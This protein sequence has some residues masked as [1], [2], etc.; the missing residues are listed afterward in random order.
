MWKKDYLDRKKYAEF[1]Y[2]LISNSDKYKRAEGE[3]AYV[4]ALDSPWGTGKSYF[5][6]I[7]EKWLTEEK[8]IQVIH[9]SAWEND[10]WDN[11]FL[12]LLYTIYNHDIYKIEATVEDSKK[13]AKDILHLAIRLGREAGL[14]KLE[15]LVGEDGVDALRDTMD[16]VEDEKAESVCAVFKEYED[17]KAAYETVRKMLR[18]NRPEGTKLLI[19]VDE[20]DRCRPDFAVQTLEVVKHLFNVE[21]LVFLFSVDMEQL[22]CVIRGIYGESLDARNYLNRLFQYVTHLPE[23]DVQ[24]YIELLFEEKKENFKEVHQMDEHKKFLVQI[25]AELVNGFQL[26]LREL[27]TIWKNYLVLYDY[28]LKEYVLTDAHLCYLL[29]L[30]MKYKYADFEEI[31]EKS[32]SETL[33]SMRELR[34]C[35]SLVEETSPFRDLLEENPRIPLREVCGILQGTNDPWIDGTNVK[36]AGADKETICFFYSDRRADTV[37]RFVPETSFAG[38]LFAPDFASWGLIKDQNILRYMKDQLELITFDGEQG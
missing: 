30:I 33:G 13:Y 28:K 25:L 31:M 5:L 35:K 37:V 27:D 12:P 3:E 32:N 1:L 14:K 29:F 22:G 10:F 34:N 36:I 20:L 16:H 38:V 24:K 26:S 11:A 4:I 15:D 21:G 6:D 23:P 18:G 19:V 8:E 17:F 7:F 2:T 9:Y